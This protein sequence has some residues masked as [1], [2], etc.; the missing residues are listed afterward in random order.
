MK[1]LDAIFM[2]IKKIN[3]LNLIISIIALRCLFQIY[4]DFLLTNELG[5]IQVSSNYL[6]IIST[7]SDKHIF[8]KTDC[9]FFDFS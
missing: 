9:N 4:G 2:S 8:L 5:L 3:G 1:V 6:N 7:F